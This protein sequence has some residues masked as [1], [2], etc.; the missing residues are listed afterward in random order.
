MFQLPDG[1]YD[2]VG[3]GEDGVDEVPQLRRGSTGHLNIQLQRQPE[4]LY[5]TLRDERSTEYE[6]PVRSADADSEE[7]QYSEL[8]QPPDNVYDTAVFNEEPQ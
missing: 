8:S 2:S 6:R 3:V 1:V 5:D 4:G 7:H